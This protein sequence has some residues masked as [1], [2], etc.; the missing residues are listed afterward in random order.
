MA[1]GS[2]KRSLKYTLGRDPSS[3]FTGSS[4]L[5]V[6]RARAA[7]RVLEQ[8]EYHFIAHIQLP[9]RAADIA[10]VKKDVATGGRDDATALPA[11]H[12]LHPAVRHL[13]GVN[14]SRGN[15]SA[16]TS[17]ELDRHYISVA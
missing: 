17:G 12:E 1:A 7:D 9:E 11:H 16:L 14:G 15:D 10:L 6:L 5:D 3:G 2:E 13:A 4:R 8:L